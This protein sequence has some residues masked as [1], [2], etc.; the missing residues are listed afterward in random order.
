MASDSHGGKNFSCIGRTLIT[1][2]DSTSCAL[3][4]EIK[5]ATGRLGYSSNRHIPLRADFSSLGYAV[6]PICHTAA[7]FFFTWFML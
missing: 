7:S 1:D 6:A 3:V 4:Y 2:L 5:G